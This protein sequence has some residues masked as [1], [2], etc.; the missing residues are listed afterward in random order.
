M[1]KYL[2]ENQINF[3]IINATKIA[4]DLGLGSPHEHDY[5]ECLL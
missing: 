5:A 3:Y 1:K 2:A 4:M